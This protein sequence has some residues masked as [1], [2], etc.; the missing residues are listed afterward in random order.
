M[1]DSE[2]YFRVPRADRGVEN[3][4]MQLSGSSACRCHKCCLERDKAKFG[5]DLPEMSFI[6]TPMGRMESCGFIVC[7]TCGNKRCPHATDHAQACT[8]SNEIGQPGSR[9]SVPQTYDCRWC[10]EVL[11][12]ATTPCDCMASGEDLVPDR[13]P[14]HE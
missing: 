12:D 13:L 2:N 5:T 6:D 8:G 14:H 1:A 11:I 4:L 10:G 3:T 7:A 9:Y